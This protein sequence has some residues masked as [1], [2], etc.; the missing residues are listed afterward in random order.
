MQS[1]L[2][3]RALAAPLG[4]GLLGSDRRKQSGDRYEGAGETIDYLQIDHARSPILRVV[5]EVIASDDRHIAPTTAM[6]IAGPP[7][8]TYPTCGSNLKARDNLK[9]RNEV[10]A[11]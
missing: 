6:Y 10:T 3:Q 9:A 2:L 1:A 4:S 5:K 11:L 7:A 8:G